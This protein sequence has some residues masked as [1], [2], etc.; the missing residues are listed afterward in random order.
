MFERLM[1]ERPF[2]IMRFIAQW[3]RR[4]VP[5]DRTRATFVNF[6]AGQF[7]YEDDRVTGLI[8]FEVSSFGDP[9]AELSGLRLRD[10]A[11]PLGD[12]SAMI[13]RYEMLTG[14]RISKQLLEYHSA[15]FCGVNGFLMLGLAYDTTLDQDYI[16]YMHYSVAT[17]RW[18]IK[19]IAEHMGLTL[20]EPGRASCR[21]RVCQYVSIS[22]VAVSLKKKSSI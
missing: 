13:D 2:P 19:D 18:A 3:L 15:G 4:N 17:T 1:G 6:D 12:L 10:A 20:T 14:D 11:E 5:Q 8:D 7:L 21:E 22:V 16:A 9:A